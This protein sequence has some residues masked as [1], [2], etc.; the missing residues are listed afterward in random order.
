[1]AKW[2]SDVNLL[3]KTDPAAIVGHS[4]HYFLPFEQTLPKEY[5]VGE[6]KSDDQIVLHKED[7]NLFGYR[8]KTYYCINK[9]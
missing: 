3:K 7:V 9:I 4:G 5:Y 2:I 6:S 8:V 1:M